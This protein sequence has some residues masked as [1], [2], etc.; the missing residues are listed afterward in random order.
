MV[1]FF[2]SRS[3]SSTL[4]AAKSS[5]TFITVLPLDHCAVS[6]MLTGGSSACAIAASKERRH[7]RVPGRVGHDA[8]QNMGRALGDVAVVLADEQAADFLDVSV[9]AVRLGL[10]IE[11]ELG[12]RWR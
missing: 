1:A 5:L 12:H 11:R 9:D 2:T 3:A 6:V 7:D 8:A 4:W 10:R